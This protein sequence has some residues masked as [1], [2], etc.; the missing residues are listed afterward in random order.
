ML[1]HNRDVIPWVL[2]ATQSSG[3]SFGGLESTFVLIEARSDGLCCVAIRLALCRAPD[4]R[5]LSAPATCYQS[6][7]I[8]LGQSHLLS[9]RKFTFNLVGAPRAAAAVAVAP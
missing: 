2:S 3:G 8:V 9:L 4:N 6:Y 5:S 1:W 7:G